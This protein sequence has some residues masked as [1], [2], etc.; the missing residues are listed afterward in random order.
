VLV[1]TGWMSMFEQN[2]ALFDSGE[3]GL[4]MSCIEWLHKH[5]ISA[6]GADNHA[7]EAIAAMPPSGLPFHFAAIR[8]LGLYLMEN[9]K[10]QPLADDR[11]Y[12]FS[13]VAAPLPLTSAV[14][15]PINPV[16]IV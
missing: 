11:Q 14:G 4:D 1:N 7:V 10:L 3:P 9:L 2:R 16:A 6:I 15:S 5:D 12:E 8:D 13:F